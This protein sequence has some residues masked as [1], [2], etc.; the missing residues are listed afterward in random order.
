[1]QNIAKILT[2]KRSLRKV[3]N[4]LSIKDVEATFVKFKEIF[5]ERQELEKK[6]KS[7]RVKKELA[8]SQ[9][10]EKMLDMGISPEDLGLKS[11]NKKIHKS[12]GKK[13]SPKYQW[14]ENGE[15][16]FW[17]GRG[18]MPLGLKKQITKSKPL[19]DFLIK[20]KK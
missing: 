8:I 10:R 18:N 13:I 20:N 2:N 17:T 1:M 9:L 16:K 7:E 12:T 5:E 11:L 6:L 14:K 4:T 15:T 3:L 19:K